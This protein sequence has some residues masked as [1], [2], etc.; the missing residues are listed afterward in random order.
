MLNFMYDMAQNKF[1]LKSE[2]KSNVKTRLSNKI[3]L[4]VR[5]PCTEKF[6]RSLPYAGP[7]K[8]NELSADLHRVATKTKYKSM[9]SDLITKKSKQNNC[10]VDLLNQTQFI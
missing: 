4:K 5:R 6:K 9:I 1:N 10:P 2:S 3:L 7:K 8:W